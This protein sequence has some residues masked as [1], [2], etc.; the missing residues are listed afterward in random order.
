MA[1]VFGGLLTG[2]E[3]IDAFA[4]AP[5]HSGTRTAVHITDERDASAKQ[6]LDAQGRE[7]QLFTDALQRN[8]R[9]GYSVVV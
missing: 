6:C 4:M 8:G 1:A 3:A 9:T 5:W 2:L 7:V